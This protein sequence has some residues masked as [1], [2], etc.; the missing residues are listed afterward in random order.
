[1]H[2]GL[3]VLLGHKKGVPFLPIQTSR[4]HRILRRYDSTACEWASRERDL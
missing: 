3:L 4:A 2:H 1:L